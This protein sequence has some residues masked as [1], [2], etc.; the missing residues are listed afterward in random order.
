[1]RHIGLAA[2]KPF[3]VVEQGA[4]SD[5]TAPKVQNDVPTGQSAQPVQ[6]SQK[7]LE[8]TAATKKKK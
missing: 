3:Q 6:G 7:P 8:K 1:M 2:N 5:V 4:Q